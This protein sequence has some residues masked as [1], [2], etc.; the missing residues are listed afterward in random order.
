MTSQNMDVFLSEVKE[1]MDFLTKNIS[2]LLYNKSQSLS[3]QEII[4]N[5]GHHLVPASSSHCCE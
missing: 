5:E 3:L 4:H 2:K 1:V